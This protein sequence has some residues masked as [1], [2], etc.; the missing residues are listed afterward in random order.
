M[1]GG[2]GS[3]GADASHSV[4]LTWG[5][6]L[7]TSRRL[8]RPTPQSHPLTA[9]TRTSQ[10]DIQLRLAR[11]RHR[12]V[13]GGDA[14]RMAAVAAAVQRQLN[15]GDELASVHITQRLCMPFCREASQRTCSWHSN[16]KMAFVGLPAKLSN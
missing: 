3:H 15:Q 14:L 13:D 9:H 5:A 8:C 1:N 12:D 2:E 16:S 7:A 10:L 6:L 4:H 11:H